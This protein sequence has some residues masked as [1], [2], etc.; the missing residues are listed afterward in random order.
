MPRLL[1]KLS[2]GLGAYCL[3]GSIDKALAL[4]RAE[5]R[6]DGLGSETISFRLA[7]SW[8]ARDIPRDRDMAREGRA[9]RLA[10]QT[11]LF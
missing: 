4:N 9:L 6:P 11:D 5:V 7:I 3:R 8:R 2:A 1:A 10:G